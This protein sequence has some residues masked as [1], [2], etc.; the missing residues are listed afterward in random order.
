MRSEPLRRPTRASVE[1]ALK[2]LAV[3]FAA[4]VVD[5]LDALGLFEGD[6]AARPMSERSPRRRR[7]VLALEEVSAKVLDVVA[8]RGGS[9]AIG[10]LARALDLDRR[11]LAHPLAL[12]VTQG[13]LVRTGTRR[14]ARYAAVEA[15]RPT[16]RRRRRDATPITPDGRKTPRS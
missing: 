3:E 1:R 10:D 11:E 4:R 2:K 8:A 15:A 13:K 9:L 12:L 7:S 6:D 5:E 14:G 16:T